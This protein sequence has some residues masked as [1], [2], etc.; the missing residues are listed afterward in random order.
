MGDEAG[1]YLDGSKKGQEHEDNVHDGCQ[2]ASLLK[3]LHQ[4]LDGPHKEHGA[5]QEGNYV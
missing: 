2:D 3:H 5:A 1:A 4:L